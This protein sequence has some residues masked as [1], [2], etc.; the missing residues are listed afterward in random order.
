MCYDYIE[1]CVEYLLDLILGLV[2][3]TFLGKKKINK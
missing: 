1:L 3:N 2:A